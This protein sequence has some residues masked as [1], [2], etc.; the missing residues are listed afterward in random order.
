MIEIIWIKLTLISCQFYRLSAVIVFVVLGIS[1]HTLFIHGADSD[2]GCGIG[3]A[4]NPI[5]LL[6][7]LIFSTAFFSL[8][9]IGTLLITNIV[10][11]LALRNRQQVGEPRQHHMEHQM[12][13][14]TAASSKPSDE[15]ESKLRNRESLERNYT[16]MLI[17]SNSVYLISNLLQITLLAVSSSWLGEDTSM[18][19]LNLKNPIPLMPILMNHSVNFIFYYA[20]SVVFRD[21]FKSF[22]EKK[23][24]SWKTNCS[25]LIYFQSDFQQRHLPFT[26]IYPVLTSSMISIHVS[27]LFLDDN[28]AQYFDKNMS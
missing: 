28:V 6:G 23:G 20:S 26:L 27:P 16:R 25:L 15:N 8:V 4:K 7:I 1:A 11:I 19:A 13:S 17:G 18:D 24:P 5:F 14:T 9:P 2:I 12:S 3:K 10:F 21:A 22:R